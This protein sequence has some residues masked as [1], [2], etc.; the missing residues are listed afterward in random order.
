MLALERLLEVRLV[1]WIRVVARSV[2]LLAKARHASKL[3]DPSAI[4]ETEVV[5]TLVVQS[6]T[7]RQVLRRLV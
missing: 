2:A 7:A 1:I 3:G 6:V 4:H 5:L